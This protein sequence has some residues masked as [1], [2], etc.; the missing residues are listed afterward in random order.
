MGAIWPLEF[1]VVYLATLTPYRMLMT[2]VYA[3]TQSLLLAILMHSSFTGW[4]LVL[5]P[6]TS[7]PQSLAWQAVFAVILW[8]LAVGVLSLDRASRPMPERPV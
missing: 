4:L 1:V 8:A 5:F 7:T 2:W 6:K 3:R